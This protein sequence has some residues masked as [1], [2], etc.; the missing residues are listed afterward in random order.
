MPLCQQCGIHVVSDL[1]TEDQ[2]CWWKS[3]E[4]CC[5]WRRAN[6]TPYLNL[7]TCADERT[8]HKNLKESRGAH[9]KR[10]RQTALRLPRARIVQAMKHTCARTL[11]IKREKGGLIKEYILSR[12]TSWPAA[13]AG[14]VCTLVRSVPQLLQRLSFAACRLFSFVLWCLP[15]P[16][17]PEKF[18]P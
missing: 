16:A 10:L 2:L 15:R 14:V 8:C 11:A 6:G 18:L 4:G 9:L 7:C 1:R 12:P 5:W 3:R 17:L 13:C